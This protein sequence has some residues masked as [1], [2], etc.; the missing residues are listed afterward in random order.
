MSDDSAWQLW[1]RQHPRADVRAAFDAGRQA[2][3]SAEQ[4]SELAQALGEK[5]YKYDTDHNAD[6]WAECLELA[7][8]AIAVL[9]P[10]T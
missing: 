7:D 10:K 8:K 4:R 6:E 2:A 3:P 9:W 1:R 5:A